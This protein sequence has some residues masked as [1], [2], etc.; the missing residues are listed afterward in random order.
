MAGE[1]A[2]SSIES[3]YQSPDQRDRDES[4]LSLRF[5]GRSDLYGHRHCQNTLLP[6]KAAKCTHTMPHTSGVSNQSPSK[7]VPSS[8]VDPPDETIP[9]VLCVRISESLTLCDGGA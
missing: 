1:Q 6:V 5:R 3:S 9:V 7:P 2:R 4:T 8:T